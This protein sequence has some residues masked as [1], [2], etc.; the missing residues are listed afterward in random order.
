MPEA[1][2]DY[3]NPFMAAK[4]I[5]SD[6]QNYPLWIGGTAQTV[7]FDVKT[8]LKVA[9]TSGYLNALSFV[10]ELQV[11]MDLGNIP[12]ITVTLAPPFEDGIKLINTDLLELGTNRIQVQFGYVAGADGAPVFRE[13][14]GMLTT[15]P[16]ISISAGEVTITLTAQ[17]LNGAIATMQQE[18]SETFEKLTRRSIFELVAI[19]YGLEIV[20]DPSTLS[21]PVAGPAL[22][23]ELIT[24]S[25]GWQTPMF[26]LTQL[27]NEARC[28]LLWGSKGSAAKKQIVKIVSRTASFVKQQPTIILSMFHYGAADLLGATVY[29]I[30]SVSSTPKELFLAGIQK[31]VSEEMDVKTKKATLKATT[32]KDAQPAQASKGAIDGKGKD[33][34]ILPKPGERTAVHRMPGDPA[35]KETL[36]DVHHAFDT[37]S[38][39]MALPLDVETIGMPTIEPGD[40]VRIRGL[41]K[42]LDQNYGV[43]KVNHSLGASGFTTAL[44]LIS[45][46]ADAL[47]SQMRDLAAGNQNAQ[48]PS[49]Q[50]APAE[51]RK[52]P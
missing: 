19:Q 21:D 9:G 33:E 40:V 11:E 17:G 14:E 16:E 26:F 3:F 18:G 34:S 37:Y 39:G 31:I 4:I 41:G 38:L 51:P 8:H 27:A 52:G 15:S 6:G 22:T 46:T 44:H 20:I 7:G 35:D 32:A 24:R 29:P 23:E 36:Q 25:Q 1:T 12:K 42:K 10:T 45:N 13:F 48:D 49:A 5:T 50:N 28:F 43:F 2:F 30:V 47:E